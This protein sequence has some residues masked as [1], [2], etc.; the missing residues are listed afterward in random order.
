MKIDLEEL[1]RIAS[2]APERAWYEAAVKHIAVNSP[3]VTLALIARIRE[4]EAALFD[5]GDA[6]NGRAAQPSAQWLI[7]LLEKGAVLP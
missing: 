6:F 7:A 3:P 2:A 4:L 5:C 1:E